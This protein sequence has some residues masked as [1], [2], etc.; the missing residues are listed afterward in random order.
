MDKRMINYIET[1]I[2]PKLSF[3]KQERL[4]VDTENFTNIDEYQ[5][6]K[7][8]PNIASVNQKYDCIFAD[9]GYNM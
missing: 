7:I 4:F 2:K 1:E 9:L 8:F 3:E 6:D 5:L